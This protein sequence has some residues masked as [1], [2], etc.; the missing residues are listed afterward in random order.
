FADET[1][2]SIQLVPACAVALPA[3][4]L[5]LSAAT[6]FILFPAVFAFISGLSV[7]WFTF[8]LT[9][10]TVLSAAAVW[11]RLVVGT[12]AAGQGMARGFLTL[13]Y[14]I[15]Q[16]IAYFFSSPSLY[17][18]PFLRFYQP[19]VAFPGF[20]LFCTLVWQALNF[21]ERRSRSRLVLF[22][23]AAGCTLGVL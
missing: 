10:A 7:F 19:A 14:L 11:I 1:S 18:L 17:H 15:P 5:G 4:W 13:P 3:R 20:F 8:S 21:Q 12:L 6:A 2:Y 9:R 16:R 22:S 23:L